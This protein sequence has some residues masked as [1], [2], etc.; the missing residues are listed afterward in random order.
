MAVLVLNASYEPIGTTTWQRAVWLVACGR[1]DLLERRDQH[2]VRTSGGETFELPSVVRL[3]TMTRVPRRRPVPITRQA[4]RV[5]DRGEC[6][7]HGCARPGTTMDHL[8]PRSKGGATSWSNVV[9]MCPRHNHSKGDRSLTEAGLHLKRQ[10][11]ALSFEIV[12]AA[13]GH[14][15]WHGW[16]GI[17]AA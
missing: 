9:L 17:A 13:K 12:L 8:V 7:V 14:P 3:R 2:L 5:R 1:C 11:V 6:Q 4:L 10:P 16:L 15:E